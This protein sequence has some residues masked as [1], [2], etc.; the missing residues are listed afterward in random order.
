MSL[1]SNCINRRRTPPPNAI[2]ADGK[3]P[4]SKSRGEGNQR[5]TSGRTGQTAHRR[6]TPTSKLYILAGQDTPPTKLYER[7]YFMKKQ[8]I[9]KR[10]G[11][12]FALT[13]KQI[14]S[15]DRKGYEIPK[16]CSCCRKKNREE[17]EDPYYG[18]H[19]AMINYTP[20]KKRR[21]RVHYSPYIVGGFR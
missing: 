5:Y 13:E 6:H 12:L 9:C 1:S 20:C 10:C 19:E 11:C 15:Y 14:K 2:Q 3:P 16:H 8:I 17:R 21:Q 7:K 4:Q 18:L